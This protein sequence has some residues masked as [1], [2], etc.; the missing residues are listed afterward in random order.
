MSLPDP[1]P[2]LVV[3]Y[4]YLWYSESEAGREDG[5]KNRPCIVVSALPCEEGRHRVV[6]LP[7]TRSMPQVG[8][9]AVE[10][11]DLTKQ[12]LGLS[13]DRQWIICSDANEFNWVG[14]DLRVVPNSHPKSFV[15]GYLGSK[16]FEVIKS[17]FL[18]A[19]NGETLRLAKR[20]E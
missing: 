14:P 5:V 13:P 19:A 15:Y 2:G 1:V 12:R 4:S 11:P 10:L 8:T 9:Q 7:V 17:K 20:A 6:L 18:F 16:L 3:C